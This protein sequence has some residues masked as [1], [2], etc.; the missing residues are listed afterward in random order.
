MCHNSNYP[1]FCSYYEFQFTNKIYKYYH[2]GFLPFGEK[3]NISSNYTK[4]KSFSSWENDIEGIDF[5]TTLEF[6]YANVSGV[7]V[8]KDGARTFGKSVAF[9]IQEYLMGNSSNP[10]Y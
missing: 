7:P 6:P 9:A 1:S 4:G 3:W 2:N 5:A 10:D 8:S